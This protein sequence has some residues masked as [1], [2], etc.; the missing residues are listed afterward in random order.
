MSRRIN[1]L[2]VSPKLSPTATFTF[3]TS[4]YVFVL[5][6]I[7]VVGRDFHT[8]VCEGLGDQSTPIFEGFS[9]RL[10][11]DVAYHEIGEMAKLVSDNVEKSI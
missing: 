9:V 3:L 11:R 6:D 5:D 7:V 10:V 1:A 4:P 2:R 8:S